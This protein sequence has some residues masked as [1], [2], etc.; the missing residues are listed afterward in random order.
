VDPGPGKDPSKPSRAEGD[1]ITAL[2][3]AQRSDGQIP[4]FNG[5][6]AQGKGGIGERD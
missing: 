4:Y 5:V 1:R 3:L 2:F 6:L